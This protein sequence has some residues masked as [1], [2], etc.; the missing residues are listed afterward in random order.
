MG[1]FSWITSDTQKSICNIEGHRDQVVMRD[2]KGNLWTELEYEGYGIFGGKDYYVLLAEMNNIPRNGMSDD[3][4]RT[5]GIDLF[6]EEKDDTLTPTLNS[7]KSSPFVDEANESCPD[8]GWN[9][10]EDDEEDDD[11]FWGAEDEDEDEDGEW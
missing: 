10:G 3:D 1:Q 8:Q 4:Y 9:T 7:H 5:L 6:F 11:D 2:N